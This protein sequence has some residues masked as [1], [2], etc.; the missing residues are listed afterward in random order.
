[1][2]SDLLKETHMSS[3]SEPGHGSD[4]TSV[5]LRLYGANVDFTLRMMALAAEN[6]QRIEEQ[7][8]QASVMAAER[9]RDAMTAMRQA[10]DG[11]AL[12]SAARQLVQEP[13]RWFATWW[14]GWCDIALH[15]QLA[16]GASVVGAVEQWQADMQS[17]LQGLQQVQ[18]GHS[19]P[20][21]MPGILGGLEP[22]VRLMNASTSALPAGARGSAPAVPSGQADRSNM[23]SASAASRT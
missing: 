5:L 9:L 1:M 13:Q 12:A 3:T 18:D 22:F 23:R 8:T 17:A 21:F 15:N 6:R 19:P 20:A 4:W 11:A 10:H 14:G 2:P 7:H 16:A